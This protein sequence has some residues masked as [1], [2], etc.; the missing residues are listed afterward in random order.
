MWGWVVAVVIVVVLAVIYLSSTAGRLDRLH[1]R[2][3]SGMDA[4]EVQLADRATAALEIA[5]S[6]LLDP[7]SSL[8]LADAAAGS[9]ERQTPLGWAQGESDLT[10]VLSTVFADPEEVAEFAAEPGGAEVIDTLSGACHKVEMSRRFY[11]DSVRACQQV[12]RH[13][14]ARLFHLAGR[15]PWPDTAEFDAV[16]PEG[17]TGR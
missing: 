17:F 10:S 3:E 12:R 7:A 4:L 15:A 13:K 9:L 6:G 14:L 5:N 2:V 16:V 11:N 1:H 8:L